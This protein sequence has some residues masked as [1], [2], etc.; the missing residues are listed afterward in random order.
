M[1]SYLHRAQRFA[2]MVYPFISSCLDD[3]RMVERGV[4]KFNNRYHLHACVYHGISRIA[5]VNSDYVVKMDY[6]DEGL[7]YGDCR[8]ECKVYKRA[9]QDGFSYLLAEITPYNY[10]DTTFYIMPRI[11]CIGYAAEQ[12]EDSI[13]PFLSDEESDWVSENLYDMHCMN[14]GRKGTRPVIVDYACV[15]EECLAQLA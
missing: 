13:Y 14:F 11:R 10:N 8:L 4:A 1:S 5:I 12:G 7:T 3:P 6:G 15:T 2:R 9:K